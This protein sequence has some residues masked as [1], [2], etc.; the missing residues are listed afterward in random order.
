R[1]IARQSEIGQR[2][3]CDVLGAADPGFQHATTPNWYARLMGH[4]VD[5]HGF[6]H[7]AHTSNL[8]VND[9]AGTQSDGRLSIA[10]VMDGFIQADLCLELLLQLGMEI[11]IVVPERLLNHQ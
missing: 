8:D 5:S 10:A 2:G 7:A 6:A 9:L 4:I 3:K 11:K 1:N